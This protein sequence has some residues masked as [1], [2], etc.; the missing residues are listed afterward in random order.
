MAEK[1][2]IL[3]DDGMQ[4]SVGTGIGTYASGL[5]EALRDRDDCD[6]RL[7]DPGFPAKGRA[8]ARVKYLMHIDSRKFKEE[9]S[10]YDVALFANFAVPRGSMPCK[11]VSCVHD[12]TAFLFPETL[13]R[14]YRTYNRAQIRNALKKADLVVTDSE[15]ARRDILGFFP[16]AEGKVMSSWLGHGE[17]F[18]EDGLPSGY[19]SDQLKGLPKSRFFLFVGTVEKRKNI[20]LL[21]EAFFELKRSDPESRGYRLV[22]A[23]RPGYGSERFE[24]IVSASPYGGDVVMP[25]YVSNADRRLLY[26]E[27]AAFLF[28]T[29]Y[30]GFGLPQVECMGH[31]LPIIVSDLPVTRD[32]SRDYGLFFALDDPASLVARMASVCSGSVDR[33]KL[34]RL[35]ESYLADFSWDKMADAY[36]RRFR[37]LLAEDGE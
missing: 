16:D 30:E 2:R 28:P 9:A 29:A 22:L 21:L 17:S 15:S 10:L 33:P 26:E 5:L 12:M 35:A 18:R 1:I 13:P 31:R 27:A 4:M 24:S 19:E 25:G 32:V 6:V 8:G 37:T 14:A 23:G 34:A 7:A 20:G 3:L 36:V 11:V